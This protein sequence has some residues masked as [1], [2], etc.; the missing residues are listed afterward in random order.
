[1]VALL[2]LLSV[3]VTSAGEYTAAKNV[4]LHIPVSLPEKKIGGGDFYNLRVEPAMADT[5]LEYTLEADGLRV[6]SNV[7]GE[8]VFRL[9]INHITKS[10][11]AGVNVRQYQHEDI[12]LHVAE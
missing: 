10:S 5:S 9:V 6:R 4:W 7:A 11:C 1:M 3:S 8:Y 2:L 12:V